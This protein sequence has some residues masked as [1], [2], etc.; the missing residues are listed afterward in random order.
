MR[1]VA[2][3]SAQSAT[4][5]RRSRPTSGDG[6]ARTNMLSPNVRI[7]AGN[8]EAAPARFGIIRRLISLQHEDQGVASHAQSSRPG[9]HGSLRWRHGGTTTDERNG[10]PRWPD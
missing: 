1:G 8:T 7:Y 10:T 2:G 6:K 4:N 3:S 5:T 9:R